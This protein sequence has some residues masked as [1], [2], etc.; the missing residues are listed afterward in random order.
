MKTKELIKLLQEVDPSGDIEVVVNGAPIHFATTLPA[1]YD[2]ALQIL[3]ANKDDGLISMALTDQGSKVM[4]YT[5]DLD[6]FLFEDPD[7]EVSVS[8][9]S[10]AREL[11]Y[12]AKIKYLRQKNKEIIE[13]ADKE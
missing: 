5:C 9:L 8:G 12:R 11:R 2:G 4:I 13:Q 6:D 3:K 1:Y 7:A 10:V